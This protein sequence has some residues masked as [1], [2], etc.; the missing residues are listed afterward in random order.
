MAD[1]PAFQ[2]YANDWLSSPGIMLM[3]PAEEGA[4]IRLLAISWVKGGLPDDDEQL[5]ILSR[6]GEDWYKGASTKIRTQF[7]RRHQKLVNKRQEV[8]RKNQRQWRL[9]SQQGGVASG[10]SRRAK[11][12]QRK[13]G[14]TVDEPPYEPNSNTPTPTTNTT[15]T[16]LIEID[17]EKSLQSGGLGLNKEVKIRAMLFGE[18]LDKIFPR[19]SRDEAT[20][21]LRVAQHLSEEVILGAPIEIFDEALGW[22]KKAMSG[23]ARNPKG[24]FVAKV[25][26]QTKFTGR[27]KL[28]NR[29]AGQG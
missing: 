26:E 7:V 8:V 18:E 12:L 21:F 11:A 15:P 14:S 24:L 9:K 29:T 2:F 1:P 6:L 22:A 17:K 5:A 20:T 3:T 28:L 19:I 25:K 23:N 10:K 16:C 13:Q 27:G 4:Y